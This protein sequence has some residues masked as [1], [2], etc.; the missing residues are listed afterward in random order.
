MEREIAIKIKIESTGNINTQ[1][2]VKNVPNSE[3]I[4][5]LEIL[6]SQ[7]TEKLNKGKKTLFEM[8]GNKDGKPSSNL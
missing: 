8:Q 7:I 5:I 2:Q 4:G 3:L 6:K 1:L